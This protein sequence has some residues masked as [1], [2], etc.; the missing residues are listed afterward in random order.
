MNTVKFSSAVIVDKGRVRGNNEDNFFF[1]GQHLTAENRDDDALLTEESSAPLMVYGVFDGMGGEALGEE[2]S[3][4]AASVLK[5]YTE[6]ARLTP[7]RDAKGAVLR[8]IREAND[9]ICQMIMERGE[10]RIGTT[11]AVVYVQNDIARVINVG[12]SRVYLYRNG[13]LTQISVDDTSVQ[14]MIE[15][16]VVAK[17]EAK[18]HASAHKL[19]QHLGIF[20]DEM[21][22]EPHISEEILIQ[23]GDMFLLCSD[24]LT[25]MVEDDEIAN[26]LRHTTNAEQGVSELVRVALEHGGKDNVTALLIRANSAPRLQKPRNNASRRKKVIAGVVALVLIVGCAVHFAGRSKEPEDVVMATEDVMEEEIIPTDVYI[27][28]L[29]DGVLPVGAKNTFLI[30]IKPTGARGTAVFTSSDPSVLMVDSESGTY[31]ALKAGYTTVTVTLGDIQSSSDVVVYE[32]I[33]DILVQEPI[34]LT[35]GDIKEVPYSVI[36]EGADAVPWFASSDESVF[37]VDESGALVAGSPGIA[38]LYVEYYGFTG[39]TVSVIVRSAPSVSG[40]VSDL[41][42][43]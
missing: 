29:G 35:V 14:R 15:L 39:K 40:G 7:E 19:T 26:I 13:K 23:K 25:D 1:N 31:E 37:W 2:A 4:I 34:Y 6:R 5:E 3:L 17:E 42:G 22:I 38:E 24:G 8:A 33:E 32:P 18:T 36:P 43:Q 10:K 12:D 11:F 28:N 16:G 21:E 30:Q 20:Q 41:F 9:Q 27:A